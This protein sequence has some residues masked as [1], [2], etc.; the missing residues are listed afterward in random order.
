MMVYRVFVL[1]AL[2]LALGSCG[3]PQDRTPAIA[4]AYVAPPT[5]N[6]RQ[7]FGIKAAVT[8]VV[9][10]GEPLD[11]LDVKRK[12]VKVRTAGGIVGWTDTNQLLTPEQMAAL[13]HLGEIAASY[14]SQ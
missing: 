14:P 5:L 4:Q 12:F 3:S 10:H 13:R 8:A 2:A 11:V 9:R 1:V 7:E 6:L